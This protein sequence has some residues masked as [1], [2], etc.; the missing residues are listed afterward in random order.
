MTNL[1]SLEESRKKSSR[2]KADMFEVLLALRL[3]DHY[4]LETTLLKKEL[5]VLEAELARF[6]NGERRVSEQQQRLNILLPILVKELDDALVPE[7]G[8]P[9]EIKWVGREWQARRTLSDINIKFS[10]GYRLGISVKSTRSGKGTQKNLGTRSLRELLGLDLTGEVKDMW[11]RVSVALSR[12]GGKL[13]ELSKEGATVI[14]K[15]KYQFPI[16]QEIGKRCGYPVQKI[17]IEKSVKLFN[18]LTPKRKLD[19]V[20]HILGIE[21]SIPLL[22]AGVVGEQPYLYWNEDF[23]KLLTG[24]LAAKMERGVK[25]YYITVDGTPILRIQANFTNGIGLSAFCE[26]AFLTI[27]LF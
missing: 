15:S 18:N 1:L 26:R 14:R 8:K 22:N 4:G 11:Q 23:N 25:G 5:A 6:L 7:S 10:S 9:V 21:E 2:S 20:E 24:T 16:I 17:G 19:F 3:S 27:D 13:A 12:R